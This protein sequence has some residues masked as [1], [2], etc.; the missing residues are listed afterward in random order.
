MLFP[1]VYGMGK[2]P[3]SLTV[4]GWSLQRQTRIHLV[5]R[6]QTPNQRKGSGTLTLFNGSHESHYHAMNLI[7]A[8]YMNC[9]QKLGASRTK[10]SMSVCQTPSAWVRGRLCETRIHPRVLI[11]DG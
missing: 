1:P 5:S 9:T 7:T 10:R 8:P 11:E 6:S 2:S 4:S 3:D